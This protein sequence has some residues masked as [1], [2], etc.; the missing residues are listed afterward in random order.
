M[1]EASGLHTIFTGHPLLEALEKK[2]VFQAREQNLLGLFPGSRER[3]VKRNFPVMLEA[4]KLVAAKIPGISFEASAAGDHRARLM[5]E[6]AAGFP[7]VI[8]TGN[9]HELMQRATAGIVCSGTATLEAAFFGLPYALIYKTAW[10]T[11]AIGRRLVDI[12]ALG[13]VNILNNY[14]IN[15]PP[16]PRLPAAPAPHIVREFIQ[17]DA[18]PEALAQEAMRLMQDP[19]ARDQLA[20]KLQS[21]ISDLQPH[22][23]SERA[24]KALLE[25][26]EETNP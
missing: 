25:T 21:I 7:V 19:A 22:G 3:E 9:A 17:D 13:I 2:R 1:Y 24:A 11:Y 16:D 18:T 14:R 20:A 6:M 23:A 26:I 8:R 10:L 5:Q 4:A 15:P 12:N